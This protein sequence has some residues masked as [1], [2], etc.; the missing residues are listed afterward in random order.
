MAG[1]REELL[2]KADLLPESEIERRLAANDG[3]LFG[4]LFDLLAEAVMVRDACGELVYANPSGL[5]YLGIDTIEELEQ[6]SAEAM[7]AEH[8]IEDEHGQTMS[9]VTSRRSV[10]CRAKTSSRC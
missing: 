3:S 5:V 1:A 8:L 6:S 2:T 9:S 4:E 7:M 10:S